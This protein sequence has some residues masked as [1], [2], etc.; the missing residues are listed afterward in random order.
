MGKTILLATAGEAKAP[1]CVSAAA[2]RV[3][4]FA[5]SELARYLK[6][7][8]GAS[9][10]LK[11]VPSSGPARLPSPALLVGEGALDRSRAGHG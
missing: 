10:R 4:R 1:I 5:A 2:D 9:F 3:T 7:M 6:R 8:T 11:K